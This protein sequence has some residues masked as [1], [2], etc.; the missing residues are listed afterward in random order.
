[1]KTGAKAHATVPAEIFGA[2]SSIN[3]GVDATDGKLAECERATGNESKPLGQ[4]AT[5]LRIE[6]EPIAG[7][8][9]EEKPEVM[10]A[11]PD[12]LVFAARKCT[13]PR[14]E[15][16]HTCTTDDVADCEA[17]CAKGRG[18]RCYRAGLLINLGE[19]D[20]RSRG[21]VCELRKGVL[22]RVVDGCAA[23]GLSRI[24]GAGAPKDPRAEADLL[25]TSCRMGSAKGLDE[26]E[27]GPFLTLWAR[28]FRRKHACRPPQRDR[29]M[30]AFCSSLRPAARCRRRESNPSRSDCGPGDA[31]EAG[32]TGGGGAT[33]AGIGAID[34]GDGATDGGDGATDAGVVSGTA[35]SISGADSSASIAPDDSATTTETTGSSSAESAASGGRLGGGSRGGID[36]SWLSGRGGTG[37]GDVSTSASAGSGAGGNDRRLIVP[38][39]VE[40]A[41]TDGGIDEVRTARCGVGSGVGS[42]SGGGIAGPEPGLND[43]PARRAS[44]IAAARSTSDFDFGSSRVKRSASP[45][46]PRNA[47]S[48][49]ARTRPSPRSTVCPVA[50]VTSKRRITP[51]G[52]E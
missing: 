32:G 1:M 41:E 22:A 6:L 45:G 34:G 36:G 3:E 33:D 21:R 50:R 24:Y 9:H 12:G 17:Q 19:G 47:A 13:L 52:R 11:C 18:E 5:I 42:G 15:V 37:V 23:T 10:E 14:A 40:R 28:S 31:S 7:K 4:C 48:L 25:D 51:V 2:S 20:C 27:I 43:S 8:A 49:C 38:G 39:R 35:C 46:W 26:L 44:R 30:A 29:R 16:A